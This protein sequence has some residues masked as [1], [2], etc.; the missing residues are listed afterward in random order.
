MGHVART[1]EALPLVCGVSATPLRKGAAG[2]G[3]PRE[4]S[5][6][7]S[8]EAAQAAQDRAGEFAIPTDQQK[9]PMAVF[10]QP[11]GCVLAAALAAASP[12]NHATPLNNQ[13][14]VGEPRLQL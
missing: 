1:Q 4:S 11:S 12:A 9:E 5:G 14:C 7:G 10:D 6:I 8:S 3:F 2:Q 13:P